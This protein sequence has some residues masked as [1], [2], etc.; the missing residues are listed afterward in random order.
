MLRLTAILTFILAGTGLSLAQRQI[1]PNYR[2]FDD[3]TIHFGFMLGVNSSNFK[4]YPVTDAYAKYGLKSLEN[5][6][7]PGGQVGIVSTLKLWTPIVRLRFVPTLSFQERVLKYYF[8]DPDPAATKDI[9][10]EERVNSTNLDFPLM[11]QFRTLRLNNFASY[12][13]VGGQYSYDLQSVE[14]SSQNYLDPFIKIKADDFQGQ[15]GA[16]VEFFAAYFKFGFE[17]K[18]SQAFSNSLIQ[19]N[20]SSSRPIDAL[21]NRVWWI[22]LI[23]EG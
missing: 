9:Y 19:D 17:V 6:S 15:V 4:S 11:L 14:K 13:L 20:T 22:S 2:K 1:A 16:G 12:V 10:N 8:E 21:Y 7:Q 3:R 5:A 23:F 18:Y